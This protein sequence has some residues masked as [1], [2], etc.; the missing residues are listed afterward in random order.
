MGIYSSNVLRESYYVTDYASQIEAD[1][2]YNSVTG[3][4]MAFLESQQNDLA[5]FNATIA[6]DFQEVAAL[7]E[8]YEVLNE[9]VSDVIEKI[10]QIF[11]KLLAKIKGIFQAFLAKLRGTF[12]SNKNL[13]D[14][15]VKQINKYYNWKDFK[16]K[17]FRKLKGGGTDAA[18]KIDSVG[19]Y[20]VDRM[21][22]SVSL[23]GVS[24][25]NKAK[26][27]DANTTLS[28]IVKDYLDDKDIDSEDINKVLIQDRL[29]S[30]DLKKEL[31]DDL[32]NMNEAFMDCVFEDADTEDEWK[33]SD[34]INGIVGS[35]L[36]EGT[37]I[38]DNVE[39][40]NKNLNSNINKI[41]NQL[42]KISSDVNKVYGGKNGESFTSKTVSMSAG[43]KMKGT[44]SVTDFESTKQD[45][46][47][48][49]NKDGTKYLDK[50]GNPITGTEASL[51]NTKIPKNSELY[52]LFNNGE[53]KIG[54]ND[55]RKN[56]RTYNNKDNKDD[57]ETLSKVASILQRVAGQ[58]QEL[59]TKFTTA[60]LTA[61]KFLVSQARKVW[62]SAA[63]YS[64][65]EH[66][67]EGY[68]FY[69]AFGEAYAYDF[70]SDMEALD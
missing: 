28:K 3:C 48:I 11:I 16:V 5:L 47:V 10:K 55:N 13:Y 22:Y 50:K 17:N 14:D 4:A 54:V 18:G 43:E 61:T 26:N 15:Y 39:K 58:E 53:I 64:S 6:N 23:A 66:K 34:I 65:T 7:Q 41:I 57:L 70:M 62:A 56:N 44:M 29:G 27:I 69:T 42:E 49:L 36:K 63:A 35:V 52:R 8:G 19:A 38:Q 40:C 67:N 9:S 45:T 25:A 37:K 21:S 60:R 51:K 12:S 2:S 33:T 32:N 59:I 20:N 46:H 30:N 31:D 1:D 68:E 24:Q